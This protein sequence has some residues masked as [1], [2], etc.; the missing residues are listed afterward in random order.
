VSTVLSFGLSPVALAK[1]KHL[2]EGGRMYHLGYSRMGQASFDK[3]R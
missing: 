3:P 2:S 1:R